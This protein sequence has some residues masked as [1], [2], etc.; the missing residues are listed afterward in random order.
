MWEKDCFVPP[1]QRSEEFIEQ[2]KIG[3]NNGISPKYTGSLYKDPEIVMLS[4]KIFVEAASP[5]VERH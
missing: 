5:A 2:A 1:N 3:Q 4:E